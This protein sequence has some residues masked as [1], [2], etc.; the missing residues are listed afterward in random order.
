MSL[1]D[2]EHRGTGFGG[3]RFPSFFLYPPVADYYV[4]VRVLNLKEGMP[5]VDAAL[6]RLERELR[7]ARSARTSL[8]KIIHGYGSTGRGGDIRLALQKILVERVGRGEVQAVIFGEDWR[9]SNEASWALIKKWP[10]LK[11]DADFG[12][13]NLGITVVVL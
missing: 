4:I 7:L 2:E 13:G 6:S 11:E 5:T 12:R 1:Q 8:I 9:I 10:E 3:G